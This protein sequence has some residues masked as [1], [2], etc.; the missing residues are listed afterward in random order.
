MENVPKINIWNLKSKCY[1]TTDHTK[2][3]IKIHATK[4]P[5]QCCLCAKKS[6]SRSYMKGNAGEKLKPYAQCAYQGTTQRD[7]IKGL[8][9]RI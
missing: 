8:L 4:K 2:C 5:Y 9:S 3:H 7:S 1:T 6:I